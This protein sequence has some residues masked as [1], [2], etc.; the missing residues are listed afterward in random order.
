MRSSR[1]LPLVGLLLIATVLR[2]LNLTGES[3][4]R[5]EI[6]IIRFALGPSQE[7]LTSF[8]RTGFN[9]PFYIV[10]MRLWLSL[11]GVNDFTLRY[12]SLLCGVGLVAI[13]FVLA[14]RLLGERA[15]FIA[16]WLTAIS[17][18]HI[19]YSGEGKMYTLQ[20]LLLLVALYAWVRVMGY[21]LWVNEWGQPITHNQQ[22]T[23]RWWVIFVIA[24]TL[25]FYTHVLSPVFLIVAVVEFL[26]HGPR[27]KM[28]LKPALV[29]LACLT[30]P[31]LPLLMW[32][33]P[34]LLRGGTSGHPFFSLNNMALLLLAD[35]SIGFGGNA[36]LFFMLQPGWVRTAC[37]LLFAI[38]ALLG[39]VRT[40]ARC[41]LSTATLLAWLALPILA[42]FA[43][44]LRTPIFEPRYLLWCAPALYMLVGAG[45]GGLEFGRL[46]IRRVNLQ[47]F[48]KLRTQSLT[49]RQAQDAVS[50]LPSSIT[51][52]LLTG[53]SLLGLAAQ[54]IQPIR[55]DLRGGA[56]FIASQMQPSDMLVF[57]I[58]Y[59]KFGFE[60]Y[61]TRRQPPTLRQ[62]QDAVSN[63]PLSHS[64]NP[65]SHFIE[66]PYTNY[67]M[68]A[69]EVSVELRAHLP[70]NHRVWLIET[71]PG[72]W[73]SRGLVRAWFD[74]TLPLIE[75][76]SFNGLTISL[77]LPERYLTYAV[78][79]PW[80]Q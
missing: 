35:W 48:D 52:T 54:I 67:G 38:A 23:T 57:Q 76:R 65:Q 26:V 53:I 45:I 50:N 69:D 21:G 58:P 17:P 64:P 55:P 80:I 28:Q 44:S 51:L 43:I 34:A 74:A 8:T 32:Q 77:H 10:L 3:L 2:A 19:W 31:Y 40:T 24:T 61:L 42:V 1:W 25:G 47:P 63:L 60:Y 59:N 12:L 29:A 68:S 6:D 14:R 71:E 49:L 22:L 37:I 5:D 46:E 73:D 13:V 9:G 72:M 79:L 66:A 62:A 11:G 36:P 78:Y 70:P 16:A 7:V 30:L 27:S 18:V 39:L 75:R 20:P 33:A 41:P 4:W 15:A 56:N